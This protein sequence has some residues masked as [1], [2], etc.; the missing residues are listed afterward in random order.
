MFQWWQRRKRKH[1]LAQPWPDSWSLHLKRNVRLSWGLDELELP[2]L[3]QR[4]KVIVAEKY[5]EGCHGLQLTEEMQV[6]IAAQAGLMLLGAPDFYFDNVRTILVYPQPFRRQSESGWIV[7]EQHR[8]GEAWQG[9]PIVLSWND[10]LRG[11]RNQNDGQNLVVHE[12][13]HALD[14]LDGEMGGN[15]TFDDPALMERWKLVMMRDFQQLA[16]AVEQ[17]RPTL[18]DPYGATSPAEF[19]AVA[20]E[21]F[22]EEPGPLRHHHP[23]L[24][25]LLKAYYRVDPARWQ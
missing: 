14:G 1:Y 17:G 19:F 3:Q 6:T 8:S 4:V 2:A 18:L 15:V 13:A 5:W 12:F 21:S 16:A 23:E 10:V 20:S 24:F 11:G 25:Q 22:F 9:G 7:D